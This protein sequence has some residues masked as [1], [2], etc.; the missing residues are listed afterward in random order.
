MVAS[1]PFSCGR[2]TCARRSCCHSPAGVGT[3]PRDLASTSPGGG[4]LR[5]WAVS[6]RQAESGVNRDEE[7]ANLLR[8][9]Q[10]YQ[11]A[12]KVMKTA[13]DMFDVLLSLG[14]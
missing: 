7:A 6:P 1:T 8:Y 11:A 5:A 12:G 10:A 4:Q 9:Q 13:S 3:K 2:R 14:R